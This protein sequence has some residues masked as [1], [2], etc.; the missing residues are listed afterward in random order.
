[1]KFFRF[2]FYV[3]LLQVL[4]TINGI[5][6]SPFCNDSWFPSYLHD[7]HQYKCWYGGALVLVLDVVFFALE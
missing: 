6:F 1:M 4:P 2:Y 3:A 7:K 5:K